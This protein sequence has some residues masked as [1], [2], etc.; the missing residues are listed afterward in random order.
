MAECPPASVKA[1]LH[2]WDVE[3]GAIMRLGTDDIRC[4]DLP[5]LGG[6]RWY[7]V[8]ATAKHAAA[9]SSACPVYSLLQNPHCTPLAEADVFSLTPLV[10]P[11]FEGTLFPTFL[12][13]T[14]TVLTG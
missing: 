9:G 3:M 6:E 4:S 1:H 11:V 8:C 7:S 10:M 2:F 14:S 5:P 13:L 12:R